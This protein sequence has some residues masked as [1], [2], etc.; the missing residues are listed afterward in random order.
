MNVSYK[1]K[2]LGTKNK[3]TDVITK[4]N[5]EIASI[6]FSFAIEASNSDV[7]PK[8]IILKLIVVEN[9]QVL[10]CYV[11]MTQ[12]NLSVTSTDFEENNSK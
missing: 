7:E 4:K 9:F 2:T 11:R 6:Q 3:M 8:T 10:M 1:K 12:Q 5:C